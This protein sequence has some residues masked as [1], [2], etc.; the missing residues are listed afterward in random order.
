M[1]ILRKI[2]YLCC[3]G[4]TTPLVDDEDSDL[5]MSHL[6]PSTIPVTTT[7]QMLRTKKIQRY[8]DFRVST[9]PCANLSTLRPAETEILGIPLDQL[10]F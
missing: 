9:P 5:I 1:D 7:P 2:A 8:A 6:P 10:E 4:T 3:F